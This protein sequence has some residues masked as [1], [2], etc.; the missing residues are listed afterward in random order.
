[1]LG[2][3]DLAKG[4]LHKNLLYEENINR[5]LKEIIIKQLRDEKRRIDLMNIVVNFMRSETA[6]NTAIYHVNNIWRADFTKNI[7]SQSNI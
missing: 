5:K 6:T 3:D 4:F 2:T 7:L 1:M